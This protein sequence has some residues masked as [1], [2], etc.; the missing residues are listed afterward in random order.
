M[1]REFW[2][3]EGK[4]NCSPLR[5]IYLTQQPMKAIY[6]ENWDEIKV[7]EMSDLVAERERT[8]KLIAALEII[9]NSNHGKDCDLIANQVAEFGLAAYNEKK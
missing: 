9:K 3:Y 8:K 4:N 6:P 5:F 7:V 2:I 1:G